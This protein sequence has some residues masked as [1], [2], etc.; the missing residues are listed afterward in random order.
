MMSTCTVAF[1]Y[2]TLK[3]WNTMCVIFQKMLRF[4]YMIIDFYF[5]SFM[6]KK[7]HHVANFCKSYS[8]E[9]FIYKI[10]TLRGSER[11]MCEDFFR[12]QVWQ[13][14]HFSYLNF[15]YLK[16]KL[17]RYIECAFS[18]ESGIFDLLQLYINQ[19]WI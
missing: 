9:K 15:F 10:I 2:M 5:L 12:F 7:G 17:K 19:K 16:L 8:T 18:I 1:A 11:F 13:Y 4:L 14:I 6:M 3:K